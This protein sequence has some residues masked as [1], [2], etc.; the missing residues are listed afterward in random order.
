MGQKRR[1]LREEL[2]RRENGVV[3]A[4]RF[5]TGSAGLGTGG[6]ARLVAELKKRGEE[7]RKQQ[8]R[9]RERKSREQKAAMEL[10]RSRKRGASTVVGEHDEDDLE[11]RTV[12]V[13]WSTKKESHSDHTLD[14][15][16][17]RFGRVESVSIEAGSGNKALVIFA[18]PDAA[19]EAVAAYDDDHETM[20]ASHIGKKKRAK[21]SS[22]APRREKAS[23]PATPGSTYSGEGAGT[24]ASLRDKESVVMMKLRQE[25]ER[26][27]IIRQ[28]AADEGISLDQA[29]GTPLKSPTMA[30]VSAGTKV[31]YRDTT[32]GG[33]PA[34]MGE[35]GKQAASRSAASPAGIGA[36]CA[37]KLGSGTR[38]RDMRAPESPFSPAARRVVDGTPGSGSFATPVF[39]SPMPAYTAAG[40]ARRENDVLSAMMRGT[41]PG[42]NPCTPSGDAGSAFAARS[43]SGISTNVDKS[44][45]GRGSAGGT[46][47]DEGDVLARMM[48]FQSNT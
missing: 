18:S 1:Q 31:P 39:P 33:A 15:L 35:G 22:F 46:P 34:R 14:V 2:E 6:E 43:D 13:K 21:R 36:E 11:D 45:R 42:S 28:M 38:T 24:P 5:S 32:N 7:M 19:D 23:P 8:G 16:F 17:S 3:G 41:A 25:A 10:E 4:R 29:R 12:R 48:R 30:P 9:E 26:Q 40:V 20:R 37:V 47:I 27:A 44:G